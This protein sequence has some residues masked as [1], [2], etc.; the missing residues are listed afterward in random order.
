[1]SSVRAA[2]VLPPPANVLISSI[3]GPDVP[4]YVGGARLSSIFPMGPV[5]EGIGLGITAVSFAGEL[6]F[7]FIAC[8]DLIEDIEELSLGLSLEMAALQDSIEHRTGKGESE[9]EEVEPPPS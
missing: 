5:L 7:G 3:R 1:M 6:S 9:S 2:N 8:A 4:L